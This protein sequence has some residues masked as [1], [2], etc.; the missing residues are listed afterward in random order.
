MKPQNSCTGT[1]VRLGCRPNITHGKG[2]KCHQGYRLG[3]WSIV[4]VKYGAI[5]RAA[6]QKPGPMP[7]LM[8]KQRNFD[9]MGGFCQPLLSARFAPVPIRSH[10]ANLVS[11]A[12]ETSED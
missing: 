2:G 6:F 3:R 4:P 8:I 11:G 10:T 5:R 1:S 12:S 9:W 7:I